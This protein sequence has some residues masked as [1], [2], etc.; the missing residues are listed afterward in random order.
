MV[1]WCD[2]ARRAART[3]SAGCTADA[4]C[5]Q[6]LGPASLSNCLSYPGTIA[7][8]K[9]EE[10]VRTDK[11]DGRESIAVGEENEFPGKGNER[12]TL[13]KFRKVVFFVSRNSSV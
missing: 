7:F 9:G 4:R 6:G 2:A 10:G 8:S 13:P 3:L 1:S 5:R 12:R 11:V